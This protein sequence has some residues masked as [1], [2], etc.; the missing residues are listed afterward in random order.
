MPGKVIQ[1]HQALLPT[2]TEIHY[3]T[4][5]AE[6]GP[7][8]ILLHGGGTDSAM[9][10]WTD[11]IPALVGAGYRIYAPDWPGYGT[12]PPLA[13][14]FKFEMLADTLHGLMDAWHLDK[15][16]L[17]GISM[18]GG[19]ALGFTLAH[20]ERVDKLVLIGSYG[21]Q[22][23]APVHKLSYLFV[24]LPFINEITWATIRASR[25]MLRATL[26]FIV[27]NPETLTEE[28]IDEVAAAIQHSHS[29]RAFAEFQRDEILW[30]GMKS[31]YMSRLHEIDVPVLL[32]HGSRDFV[33]PVR[34]AGEAARLLPDVRLHV[35]ENAGHWTQRD[36]PDEVNQIVLDFLSQPV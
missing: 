8:I 16:S 22:D 31:C 23:K 29:Q 6:D 35:V 34:Y 21:L 10:S 18:G 24:R 17:A 13:E 15:V 3:Y 28:L 7:P 19:A 26:K 12:S 14:S 33:V 5:G 27:R 11:T 36:Y 32:V 1:K 4:S 9:L 20:P 30:Q 25:A 2:G